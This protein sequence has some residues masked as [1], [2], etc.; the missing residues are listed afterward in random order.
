MHAMRHE[1]SYRAEG[2]A[3][4]YKVW[5][6]ETTV[7]GK[8]SVTPGDLVR[9]VPDHLGSA[10]FEQPVVKLDPS[11]GVLVRPH[12]ELEA[13]QRDIEDAETGHAKG[14]HAKE[15]FD[16]PK[17]LRRDPPRAWFGP[18]EIRLVQDDNTDSAQGQSAGTGGS[19]G[20]ASDD[21]HIAVS[22]ICAKLVTVCIHDT[23]QGGCGDPGLVITTCQSWLPRAR[24][25]PAL[26][27]R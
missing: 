15:G 9:S 12:T 4:S 7:D 5:R 6:T 24:K 11:D 1:P 8:I 10:A 16:H 23:R 2:T 19:R 22:T 17:D 21:Q 27:S 25:P 3:G 14:V 13:A 26:E 18:W 20:S